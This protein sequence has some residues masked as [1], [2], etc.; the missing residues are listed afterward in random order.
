M[1]EGI[2]FEQIIYSKKN[3][4]Q[5]EKNIKDAQTITI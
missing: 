2:I 4:F 5:Q 3:I 1:I